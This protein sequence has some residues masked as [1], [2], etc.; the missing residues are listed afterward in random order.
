MCRKQS[1]FATMLHRARF[2]HANNNY[3]GC[4]KAASRL[5]QIRQEDGAPGSE[6]DETGCVLDRPTAVIPL[7]KPTVVIRN[8]LLYRG[9]GVCATR[10]ASGECFLQEVDLSAVAAAVG[11][12]EKRKPQ[13]THT[14]KSRSCK[15]QR[16][17]G[18]VNT[19]RPTSG[20]SH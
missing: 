5:R 4:A 6:G 15:I 11:L 16:Y 18:R 19:G 2:C 20:E 10:P 7:R 14:H 9:P 13:N 12:Q 1:C 8:P 3:A 17:E